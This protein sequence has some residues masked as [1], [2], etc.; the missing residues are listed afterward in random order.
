MVMTAVA[1]LHK[2]NA[3]LKLVNNLLRAIR[4]PPLGCVVQFAAANDDPEPCAHTFHLLDLRHPAFFQIGNMNITFEGV[5]LNPYLKLFLKK[6]AEPMNHVIGKLIRAVDERIGA[7]DLFDGGITFVQ[8]RDVRAILPQRRTRRA[9]IRLELSRMSEMEVPHR[10]RE[11]Q[12]ISGTE[13][14]FE[15]QLSHFFLR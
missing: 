12:N 6:Q 7:V 11:H 2:T 15:D 5:R 4:V 3:A 14:A 10:R 8:R 1:A 13:P 9:H